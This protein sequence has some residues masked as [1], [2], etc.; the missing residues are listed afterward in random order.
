ML[1]DGPPYLDP[2]LLHCAHAGPPQRGQTEEWTC[3]SLLPLL[4]CPPPSTSPPRPPLHLC[5]LIYPSPQ[6]CCP[7][8][9]PVLCN[10]SLLIR[11]SGSLVG[12]TPHPSPS[13]LQ[14][15]NERERHILHKKNAKGEMHKNL[16]KPDCDK[17]PRLKKIQLE[18]WRWWGWSWAVT[19]IMVEKRKSN[20]S[21]KQAW[22]KDDSTG[23]TDF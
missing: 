14:A 5:L 6:A 13:H 4:L 10:S 12:Q 9:H 18:N 19:A 15:K 7:F 8:A 17:N 22:K 21:N 1:A 23:H 11:S 20:F 3:P 16:P 2:L